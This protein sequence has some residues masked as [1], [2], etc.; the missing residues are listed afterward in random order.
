MPDDE[1]GRQPARTRFAEQVTPGGFLC[2]EVASAMQKAIRRGNEREALFWAS[3]L[4]LA[5]YGGYVWKRLR[6]IASEDVGLADT[7][8]VIA[9]RVLYDNW[10]EAK[11][12]KNEDAMPLFLAHA[13]LVLARAAK[14]GI[15]VHAWMTFYEGDRQAMAMEIPDHALDMHTARGRRMGRG[16]QHFLEEAGRLENETLPDPYLAEGAEAWTKQKPK[17]EAPAPEPSSDQLELG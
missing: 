13:V 4:D 12:A 17:Q 16:K 8:A 3:E 5:G 14:S 9:T 10:L 1:A 15:A 11:K 2:G 7:E 6:I